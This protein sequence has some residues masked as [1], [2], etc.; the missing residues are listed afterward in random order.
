MIESS[1]IINQTWVRFK[2]SGKTDSTMPGKAIKP[3][4]DNAAKSKPAEDLKP[5]HF[6]A[7]IN[8]LSFAGLETMNISLNHAANHIR[9]ADTRMDQINENID[10]MKSELSSI[11][12]NYPPFPPGSEDRV[13]K[14]KNVSSFRRQIAQL[15][16]PREPGN[17]AE[18]ESNADHSVGKQ[19]GQLRILLKD[20]NFLYT[21]KKTGSDA[22]E[23]NL[24]EINQELSD[25]EIPKIIKGLDGE[26]EII[27]KQRKNLTEG[28]SDLFR[29]KEDSRLF[30]GMEF[31][32]MDNDSA[33][34]K[35][36]SVGQRLNNNSAAII[37]DNHSQELLN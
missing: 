12:K 26:S 27:A 29:L 5:D 28:A 7:D 8:R 23:I 21:I 14:L 36:M 2:S 15:T 31:P 10:K 16:I 9:S 34:I 13:R 33:D 24:P 25:D 11:V 35:S 4:R 3:Q 32:G 18:V 37:A 6:K 22:I 17:K 1:N 19:A 20:N 30:A